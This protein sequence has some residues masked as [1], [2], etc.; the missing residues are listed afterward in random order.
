MRSWTNI[1]FLIGVL[2]IGNIGYGQV[3]PKKVGCIG[4]SVTK[5][6]GLK[7][8]GQS[9]PEQLQQLLGSGYDVRN[10]GYS[11]ATLLAQGHKPYVE[12]EVF[13]EALRFAPDIIVV[14]LGLNDTD[15]RNWPNYSTNFESDYSELIDKFRKVNPHVEVYVCQLTPIFAGHPRFLSGTR[16]WFHQIQRLI[17]Q[18]ARANEAI[19]IDNYSPLAARMDLFDDFLHPNVRGAEIIA[20]NVY[21]ALAGV[22]QPFAV[23]ETVGSHM[24]LQRNRINTVSGKGTTGEKVQLELDGAVFEAPVDQYG[25]WS[26]MIPA[27]AAG[28]P[29]LIDISCAGEKIQLTDILFGDV[30]LASGQSNMAF[31]VKAANGGDRILAKADQNSNIRIFKAKNLVETTATAWDSVT[32]NKINELA[33]F[34]GKWAICSKES[35]ADF[36][37]VAYAFAEEVFRDQHIPIGIVDISV[38]GSNTESW[39]PLATLED[40]NLLASYLH[41]WRSSDFI[42][43]F[44]KER[45]S[46]NLSISKVKNQAHPYAPGYNFESGIVKWLSTNLTG[47]LWYQGESNAHNVEHHD[48][49]FTTLVSSWRSRFQQDLPFYFVQLSSM[50]RPSWGLFRDHQRLLAKRIGNTHMAVSSDWG[51]PKDV[52][53]K[54]KIIIGQR[55]AN[56][57]FKYTYGKDIQADTPEPTGVTIR[58]NELLLCFSNCTSL[59]TRAGESVRDLQLINDRG[60]EV[61]IDDMEI[62]GNYLRIRFSGEPIRNIRYGYLGYTTANLENEIGIPVSTFNLNI[63]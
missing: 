61:K 18:I 50:E 59:R 4:D 43:G 57:A 53:P 49:L 5:G 62:R 3:T 19:L 56:L 41:T 23:D 21:R 15:P 54:E 45:A 20:A 47:I 8:R 63:N 34:S 7:Q 17:P 38:G 9:Y 16:E 60:N 12:T 35:V 11:G 13:A 40:D 48:Y 2:V 10:F 42:Q 51:D 44:C 32:C 14:A 33:Y 58:D 46:L 52:H 27:K 1:F 39:I 6:L 24:V 30:Y 55:L 36:S 29:Y 25:H 37:A 22:R 31:P 26:V 28:G